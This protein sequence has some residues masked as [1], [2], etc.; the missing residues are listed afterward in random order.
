MQTGIAI[1]DT[2][3]KRGS[4]MNSNLNRGGGRTA[5]VLG[6]TGTTKDAR[7]AV[8]APVKIAPLPADLPQ[9]DI[10][11]RRMAQWAMNY[12]IRTPRKELNYEPVFQCYPLRC[13]PVPAGRDVVVPCD[14]DGRLNWEWYFM[15]DIS[16]SQ[17][18]Q[19]VEAG[20]HKR[21]LDYVQPDGTVLAHPGCYN[22][23]DIHKVYTKEE[24]CYH[25]WGATRILFAL[26][27][28][29]RRTG[30]PESKAIARRIM[31]RLKKNAV[32]TAPDRC[33]FP[34]GIGAMKLDGTVVPNHWNKMPAPAVIALVHYYRATGDAEALEFAKAYAEG[35]M[36]GLQPGGLRFQA[37]GDFAGGH[38]HT[39]MHALWGLAELGLVTGD[40]RHTDFVKRAW[41]W[42]LSLGTGTGWFPA[43]TPFHPINETCLTSDMMSCAACIAR[44]GHPEYF[45]FVE[46]YMRN[47]ISLLQF[48]VTPEF[49][50]NYRKINAEAGEEKIQAGLAELRK[51]QGGIQSY[52][53]LDDYENSRLKGFYAGLAGCCAPEGMRAIW[54]TWNNTIDR[55]DASRLG[56]AGV[57][58][59]MSFSRTSSWGRVVS[60]L[61]D[62]G[63]LTVKTAIADTFL[64]RPPHWAPREC[65]R[66]FIGA[67]E[68]PTVWSGAYIRFDGSKPGDELTV[69]Y[70]LVRFSHTPDGVWKGKMQPVVDLTFDW[71]GNTIVGSTPPPGGKPLFTGAPRSLPPPPLFDP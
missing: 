62:V 33:Y 20:F 58:V 25:V 59:N 41:D 51:V 69:T 49:E 3:Q 47:Q 1:H 46:R 48:F 34:A 57:Y 28:D 44:G 54:T 31:L 35:I 43:A 61:P 9:R 56:P 55:L 22:E 16:G 70:P 4:A 21:M 67:R 6:L 30:N 5:K 65:V 17:A 24:Y 37:S 10:D 66:A 14:T 19:D 64:L 63:R 18:G 60:F 53:G 11:L 52:S 36:A 13:P 50:A 45:D 42:M 71:V 7:I 68:I 29:F 2:D 12:L 8:E 26:A 23:G 15:R 32:Y 40:E 39:T 38:S 27:E